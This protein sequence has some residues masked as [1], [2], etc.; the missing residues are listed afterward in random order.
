MLCPAKDFYKSEDLGKDEVRITYVQDEDILERSIDILK[1]ALC[2]Y[3]N[4]YQVK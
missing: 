2:I 3:V 4:K 1:K